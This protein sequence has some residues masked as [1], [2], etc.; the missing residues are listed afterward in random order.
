MIEREI[1][2][3]SKPNWDRVLGVG[4]QEEDRLR[5]E[6]LR[7]K[8]EEDEEL[9]RAMNSFEHADIVPLET[10]EERAYREE[11]LAA[12]N[13][14][15]VPRTDRVACKRIISEEHVPLH[16]KN[17]MLQERQSDSSTSKGMPTAFNLTHA[18]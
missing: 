15:G 1:R 13:R 17:S 3:I 9:I 10:E 5:T 8:R 18:E 14:A 16:E 7:E 12:R 11:I 2:G 4:R 6:S